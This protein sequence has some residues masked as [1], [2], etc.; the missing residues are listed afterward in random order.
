MRR[1]PGAALGLLAMLLLGHAAA[2]ANDDCSNV[3][4]TTHDIDSAST[5]CISGPTLN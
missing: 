2:A 1:S 3:A 4:G 5:M